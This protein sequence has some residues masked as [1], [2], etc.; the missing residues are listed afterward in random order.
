MNIRPAIALTAIATAITLFSGCTAY[1][2]TNT[3]IPQSNPTV[4]SAPAY[5]D[6]LELPTARQAPTQAEVS[7]STTKASSGT[8]TSRPSAPPQA[9]V[10]QA[11]LAKQAPT[12]KQAG[13]MMTRPKKRSTVLLSGRSVDGFHIGKAKQHQ[14]LKAL[15]KKLGKPTKVTR[16]ECR[17]SVAPIAIYH[18]QG[19]SVDFDTKTH[20]L[21]SWGVNNRAG[22][23]P[24]AIQLGDG[25]PLN[26]TVT[27]LKRLDPNAVVRPMDNTDLY[28][29]TWLDKRGYG[30]IW[31]T[32]GPAPAAN[33]RAS[34]AFSWEETG[35]W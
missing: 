22:G 3:P 18:W 17:P 20:L 28:W 5:A 14:V 7:S 13:T 34:Q 29:E 30:Y 11:R 19:F 26:P 4:A 32:S 33:A 8:A 21:R 25:A 23:A 6:A 1:S 27:E 16:L 10:A 15:T 31:D 24:K 2:T 12:A 9:P 35:C